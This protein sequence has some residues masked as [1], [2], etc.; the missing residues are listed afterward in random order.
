[1]NEPEYEPEPDSYKEHAER[2]LIKDMEA[3]DTPRTDAKAY[4]EPLTALS[5]VG[6][7]FA[8]ELE[9][10]NSA[11]H[12]DMRRMKRL[13]AGHACYLGIRYCPTCEAIRIAEKACQA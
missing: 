12:G 5:V 7:G 2:E 1:M 4:E 11:L 13:L 9:R 8:R 10:E 6:A 3:S